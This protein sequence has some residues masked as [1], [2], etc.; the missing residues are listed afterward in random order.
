MERS[1]RVRLLLS[2]IVPS[3]IP[4]HHRRTTD[5]GIATLVQFLLLALFRRQAAQSSS[6][7][8]LSR[9]SRYTFLVQSL[10]DAIS[11]VGVRVPLVHLCPMSLIESFSMSQSL[12]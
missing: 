9:V 2:I 6:A 5:S 12:F 10:I 4:D 1:Q 3:L 11:F 8:G 7:G